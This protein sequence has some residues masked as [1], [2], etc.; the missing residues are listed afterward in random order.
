MSEFHYV[1]FTVDTTA[2]SAKRFKISTCNL[3]LIPLK[4]SALKLQILK[5]DQSR[6]SFLPEGVF[7]GMNKLE[8]LMIAGGNLNRLTKKTFNGLNKLKKL[9]LN[10]NNLTRL[11][12]DL[13]K[14]QQN[15][16]YLDIS[17]NNFHKLEP[18][19]F[20]VLLVGSM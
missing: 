15:L 5:I 6:I 10:H 17:H 11:D 8:E 2:L 13:F 4:S 19:F 3:L 20:K 16:E 14:F 7:G 1:K 9:S 18:Y 12:R